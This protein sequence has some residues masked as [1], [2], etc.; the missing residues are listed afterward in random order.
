MMGCCASWSGLIHVV[1]GIGIGFL[2]ASY[3]AVPN[4]IMWGWVLVVA[5]ALGHFVGWTKCKHCGM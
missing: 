1:G 4:M 5:S 3:I 2:L